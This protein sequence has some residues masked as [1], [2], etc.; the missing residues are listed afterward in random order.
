MRHALL[1]R[2]RNGGRRL[3]T[4]AGGFT[5]LEVL[6]AVTVM[7]LIL[8][9]A[10][11]ALRLG[12]RSWEAGI[13]RAAE[14]EERRSVA[15]FLQRQFAQA[16]PL[17]WPA[18]NKDIPLA[19]DGSARQVRFIAPSPQQQSAAGLFEFALTAERPEAG[20]AAR[21][22]LS[23]A[24]FNP[25]ATRF[26][27]PGSGQRVVLVDGLKSASFA[28][29]GAPDPKQKPAWQ[30]QWDSDALG[31]PEMIRV[32]LETG[33]TGPHWPELLLALRIGHM[34]AVKP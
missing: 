24:P 22:V 32:Q 29:Y 4:R 25:S 30:R 16:L 10:F 19:F 11:G 31:L 3:P 5:L 2:L 18:D 14:T 28:Y 7:G 20:A 23:Y 15:S 12:S 1:C 8:T 26:R 6:V 27:V 33:E 9:A 34:Q 13:A 17:T 21:L